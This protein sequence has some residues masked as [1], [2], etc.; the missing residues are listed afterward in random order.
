MTHQAKHFLKYYSIQA[1]LSKAKYYF[2]ISN[3]GILVGIC[4]YLLHIYLALANS[5]RVRSNLRVLWRWLMSVFL[6][7]FASA[8]LITKM[9]GAK[10]WNLVFEPLTMFT[11]ASYF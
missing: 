3:V 11:K 10:M 8:S 5:H 1:G 2:W 6:C 7:C 9:E 4:G